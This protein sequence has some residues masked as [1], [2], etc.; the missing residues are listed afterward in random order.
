VAPDVLVWH[1]NDLRVHDNAALAA[2]AADGT[3]HPVFVFDPRFYRSG[4]V[5]DGRLE[6]LHESLAQLDDAYR[7][8]GG[9][10]AFRH[11]DPVSV[12]TDLLPEFDRIHVN[13]GPTSGYA[14]ERDAA[15]ADH[16]AVR[17]FE[18]DPIVREGDTRDGWSEG[19]EA[20]FEAEP[21]DPP[22]TVGE[23]PE[24][25]T[26]AAVEERYGVDSEKDRRHRG[27]HRRA[28]ERLVAFGEGVDRYVG[29]IS[30]PAAAEERTSQLSPYFKFGCL[31]LREAYQHVAE[32]SGDD[33]AV[34]MFHSRLFW[35]GHFRQKLADDPKA[36]ERAVNPVFRGMNRDRHDPELAAA[37]REGRTGFPLVDASMRALTETG[38]LN[39]RMRAMCAT[40]YTYVL[41]CYWKEG[42]DWYYRHL[43]D[44]DPGIN[45]E[46]WQMQSGLV[47]VHPL[48][49]YDPRKQVRDNDPDGTFVGRYVPELADFPVEYLDQPE[50][51]PLAV[52]EECGVRIGED[53]PYPVVDYERRRAEAREDWAALT[54]RAREAL[55]DPEVRRRASLSR[56]HSRDG[57]DLGDDEPATAG[58]QADLTD[59]G[60]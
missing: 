22:A 56:R 10:L 52:Q 55:S 8:R 2:A 23:G 54:D 21:H 42:A 28:R 17:W 4:R 47:G 25:T 16:D 26:I 53:Y 9:R 46:Q 6:F 33:R 12:L 60:G 40:F 3:A 24:S 19:A 37:W 7:D 41:R 15:L 31:S 29:G 20:Y 57:S 59:F 48:R 44:A 18:D 35:N 51:A 58:G 34:E 38:W 30:A 13:A 43:L 14:R 50:K 1:R 39:F 32:A 49:L 45:Y 5:C 36:T 27:G 11:G